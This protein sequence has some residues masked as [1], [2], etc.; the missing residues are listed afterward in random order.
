MKCTRMLQRKLQDWSQPARV[1][2]IEIIY[3]DS[4]L[5]SW[6]SLN[7]RGLRGLKLYG[8]GTRSAQRGSQPARVEGIEIKLY[9]LLPSDQSWSQPA[10]VEGIEMM[11]AMAATRL[12]ASV[13]TREG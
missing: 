12:A 1:E 6:G 11:V 5:T 2:G 8:V 4:H 10:R 9:E 3:P 7:P 13:S